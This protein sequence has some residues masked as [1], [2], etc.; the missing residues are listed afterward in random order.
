M[1]R[2]LSAPKKPTFVSI[3]MM[4]L[5]AVSSWPYP[6]LHA[7]K[8]MATKKLGTSLQA[9]NAQIAVLQAKADAIRKQ[10][11]GE[12]VAKIKEAIA[13]YGLTAAD[14]GLSASGTTAHKTKNTPKAGKPGRKPRATTARK[15]ARA[16]KYTDSQGRTWSGVGKRPDW[17]KAALA[18][19]KTAEEL[20][21]KP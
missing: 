3:A 18:A 21:V 4:G 15:P 2:A 8:T 16:A 5:K 9:I 1:R 6:P 10:E 7:F 11:V 14:L 20:L 17:F 13:H 12:V 19:G